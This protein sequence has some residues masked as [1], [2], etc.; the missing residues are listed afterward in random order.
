MAVGDLIQ[1]PNGLYVVDMVRGSKG[2]V[3]GVPATLIDRAYAWW[4][5]KVTHTWPK[6]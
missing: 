4:K 1:T 6:E 2:L 3:V 5:G